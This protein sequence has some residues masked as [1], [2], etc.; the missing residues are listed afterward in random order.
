MVPVDEDGCDRLI[1]LSNRHFSPIIP[2]LDAPLFPRHSR[3]PVTRGSLRVEQYHQRFEV[4]NRGIKVTENIFCGVIFFPACPLGNA[5]QY[6]TISKLLFDRVSRNLRM[7]LAAG[8]NLKINMCLQRM[9]HLNHMRCA[10]RMTN[11]FEF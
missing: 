3:Q 2:S 4:E 10:R 8:F 7:L 5:L 1:N 11:K 6:E 9:I